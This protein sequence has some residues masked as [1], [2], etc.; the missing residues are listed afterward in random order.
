MQ[1]NAHDKSA[2]HTLPPGL[3]DDWRLDVDLACP[4]CDFNLR[5]AR[6]PRCNECGTTFRWQTLL[7][8]GCPR[9]GVPLF[10]HDGDTCPACE[11]SLNWAALFDRADENRLQRYEYSRRP[12]RAAISTWISALFPRRFWRAIPLES[13][14]N[15]RRL[16]RL[17]FWAWLVFFA[18]FAGWVATYLFIKSSATTSYMPAADEISIFSIAFVVP[19]IVTAIALPLFGP[20][21]A[22]LRIRKD[23]VLRIGVYGL[24]GLVWIAA[25]H[26]VTAGVMLVLLMLG[27]KLLFAWG[28]SIPIYV[29]PQVGIDALRHGDFSRDQYSP[30]PSAASA[31]FVA[32]V[33]LI[34]PIW[35]FRYLYVALHH[36][37]RLPRGDTWSLLIASQI[38]A[39]LAS[40]LVLLQHPGWV[41]FLGH[42]LVF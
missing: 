37:L 23:Q 33:L 5:T 39:A 35:W 11:L 26:N 36:Y 10:E 25:I 34:C 19:W 41:R 29:N 7:Q 20:T 1:P 42:C 12:I 2:E 14:P 3:P 21:L 16:R 6:T 24:S 8:V 28:M 18:A 17:G 9:C 31:I 30:I 38:I 32:A 13:P 4:I 27:V 22:R 15:V 40:L